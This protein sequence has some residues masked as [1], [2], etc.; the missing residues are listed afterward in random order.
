MELP[1]LCFLV[2]LAPRSLS[3]GAHVCRPVAAESGIMKL[4]VGHNAYNSYMRQIEE[5]RFVGK[6]PDFWH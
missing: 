4:I 3:S 5:K 2:R 1:L 6:K